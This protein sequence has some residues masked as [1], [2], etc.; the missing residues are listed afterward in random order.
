LHLD[1]PALVVMNPRLK[2]EKAQEIVNY[3]VKGN[4]FIVDRLFDRAALLI[5]NGK[6]AESVDI[7]RHDPLT[8]FKTSA[9]NAPMVSANGGS[10]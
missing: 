3:R 7:R 8:T 1:L 10:K 6:T 5:G 4:L 2:G 9:T